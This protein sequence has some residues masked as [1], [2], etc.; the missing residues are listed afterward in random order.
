MTKQTI[1]AV[2]AHPDDE[3]FGM[4]GTL[5]LYAERGV[6]GLAI[7]GYSM[8]PVPSGQE[9]F[10]ARQFASMEYSAQDRR[11]S[12]AAAPFGGS[13][14]VVLAVASGWPWRAASGQD[15]WLQQMNTPST[16]LSVAKFELWGQQFRIPLR[17]L[18]GGLAANT[19]FY[20]PFTLGA[21]WLLAGLHRRRRRNNRRCIACG[22]DLSAST[23]PCPECGTLDGM[24]AK[25]SA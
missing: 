10:H 20:T 12:W 14:E 22:Y 1:L 3:S 15:R 25:R 6:A 8:V 2:L 21:L 18:W 11:P 9:H 23:G 16:H 7:S 5:A 4:G 19:V 13:N 17:P 24:L